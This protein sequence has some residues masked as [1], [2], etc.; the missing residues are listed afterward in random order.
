MWFLRL[1]KR[2]IRLF[3]RFYCVC[4]AINGPAPDS[5]VAIVA[6]ICF[7]YVCLNKRFAQVHHLFLW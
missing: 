1:H 6:F 2:S 5:A 4:N 7:F 3:L